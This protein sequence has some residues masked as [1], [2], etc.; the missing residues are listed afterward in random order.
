MDNNKENKNANDNKKPTLKDSLARFRN[1]NKLSTAELYGTDENF[2]D[3]NDRD[4]AEIKD[5]I[6]VVTEKYKKNTGSDI[7]EFF[8]SVNYNNNKNQVKVQDKNKG[9]MDITNMIEN[10]EMFNVNEIFSQETNRFQLYSSYNLIYENI[11]QMAQ[12]LDTY[13]DNIMSPDDF[14][15]NIF[16]IFIDDV[17]I[18]SKENS[19]NL[20]NNEI[21]KNCMQLIEDYKLETTANKILTESLTLGDSFVAVLNLSDEMNKMMLSEDYEF[22]PNNDGNKLLTENDIVLSDTEVI[23]LASIL[24]D[25]TINM[26]VKPEIPNYNIKQSNL[27]RNALSEAYNLELNLYNENLKVFN[28]DKKKIIHDMVEVLNHNFIFSE[29]SK[30]LLE[31]NVNYAKEFATQN[32]VELFNNFSS[33]AREKKSNNPATNNGIKNNSKKDKIQ[34]SG[35]VLKIL[36]PERTIKLSLDDSQ[37]EYGYY[38]IENMENSPDFLTTGSYSV[39]SN[40]FTTFKSQENDKPDMVNAKYRLITDIFVRNLSKKIDKKFINKHPEFKNT[41]YNLIK[42]NFIL[43]KQVRM[44]YLRPDEVI[45]F[46][47]GV[48]EYKDSLFK[49]ILFSAKLYLSVLTSQV[50]LRLVRS[51]EKRVF[52]LECAL[53]QDS[54]NLVQSFIRDTKTKDIKLSNFGQDINTL[55]QSVGTFQDYYIPVIENSK[56]VEIDTLP[57][58]NA[59]ITNDFLEYLLKTMISGLGIPPEYLSY[60][61][62]TE[63]ARSLGMMN[64]KFVRSIIVKQKIYGEQFTKMFRLLYKNEFMN[65]KDL[66]KSSTKNKNNTND[67]K[68]NKDIIFN[69]NSLSVKF[70]SPQSLNM[71]AQSEQ[72]NASNDIIEFVVR[73][74]VDDDN[75]ELQTEFRRQVTQDILSSFDWYKYNNILEQSKITLVE[76][77]L[78][79]ATEVNP[80]STTDDYSSSY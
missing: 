24:E 35:S 59:E 39:S 18:T 11:P 12:A 25:K 68:T 44:I 80:D 71:S 75:Q 27:E 50:M 40:I 42:Q 38:Y 28:E 54:E 58:M 48:N 9:I 1:L 21:I 52:Y 5:K 10:P 79:K 14:T 7:I 20:E 63:F 32:K 19:N 15:K 29:D 51:P 34:L 57:G 2:Q 69:L 33:D 62:N 4:I 37:V 78:E 61:E 45:H 36:K 49:K 17:N 64:G 8:N 72:I 16:N 74:L 30:V 73:T 53:D 56:P 43:N 13:V 3:E 60:T 31:D 76:N 41:M 67:I 22:V 66:Q 46:G 55:L 70:P 77:K 47:I 23:Q 6:N 26:P 65:E